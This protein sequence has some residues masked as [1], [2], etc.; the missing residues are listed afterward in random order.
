MKTS[1]SKCGETLTNPDAIFDSSTSNIVNTRKHNNKSTAASQTKNTFTNAFNALFG[2]SRSTT[3]RKSTPDKEPPNSP[4]QP[5]VMDLNVTGSPSASHASS[6]EVFSSSI[7]HISGTFT[8]SNSSQN[9]SQSLSQILESDG[10]RPT[11]TLSAPHAFRPRSSSMSAISTET[12]SLC[13]SPRDSLAGSI[14]L[15]EGY[16]NKKADTYQSGAIGL[17]RGWK[18]YR[19][20]LKGAKLYFYKPPTENEIRSIFP[21]SKNGRPLTISESVEVSPK[22]LPVFNRSSHVSKGLRLVS[23]SFA[24]STRALLFEPTSDISNDPF[25]N[26]IYNLGGSSLSSR[27]YF[28]ECFTE[29]DSTNFRFKRYVCLLIFE[30]VLMI[31]KRK[32]VKHHRNSLLDVVNDAIRLAGGSGAV[33]SD[34]FLQSEDKAFQQGKG[35]FTKW[36]HDTTYPLD[37]IDIIEA[38]STSFI[39]SSEKSQHTSNRTTIFPHYNSSVPSIDIDHAGS[40]TQAIQIF[41]GGHSSVKRLFVAKADEEQNW[42]YK[43]NSA[44]SSLSRKSSK[45]RKSEDHQNSCF[46]ISRTNLSNTSIH[47]DESKLRSQKSDPIIRGRLYWDT[48]IHPE[49]VTCLTVSPDG[50][51]KYTKITGGSVDSLIHELLFQN[52]QSENPNVSDCDWFTDAFLATYTR[53]TTSIHFAQELRR[54]AIMGVPEELEVAAD[55]QSLLVLNRLEEVLTKWITQPNDNIDRETLKAI[56][57]IAND[58]LVKN[59]NFVVEEFM[60][61]LQTSKTK[62]D[63][64]SQ[65]ESLNMSPLVTTSEGNHLNYLAK[66][67]TSLKRSGFSPTIFLKISAE[68]FAQE[69][70]VFHTRCKACLVSQTLSLKGSLLKTSNANT[71]ATSS[72]FS[73]IASV[74]WFTVSEPHFLTK[75]IYNHLITNAQS[76]HPSRRS[77]IL[78][79]WIRV[80]EACKILGDMVSWVAIAFA[81]CSPIVVRLR[82]TWKGIDKRMCYKVMHEWAPALFASG[83]YATEIP[84]VPNVEEI[85][86]ELAI[87]PGSAHQIPYFGGIRVIVDRIEMVVPPAIPGTSVI[88]FCKYQDIYSI[89]D[90]TLTTWGHFIQN[91]ESK[92]TLSGTFALQNYFDHLLL[93]EDAPLDFDFTQG[94]LASLDCEPVVNIRHL[95]NSNNGLT[96]SKPVAYQ[97]LKFIPLFSEQTS[98]LNMVVCVE[99]FDSNLANEKYS[100]SLTD[101]HTPGLNIP[102][103]HRMVTST[104]FF[105]GISSASELARKRTQS[106]PSNQY[107]KSLDSD[108]TS[109]WGII[110]KPNGP[111]SALYTHDASNL[112]NRQECFLLLDNGEL[113]FTLYQIQVDNQRNTFNLVIKGGL[114]YHLIDVLLF[115]IK[116]KELSLID[117]AGEAFIFDESEEVLFD[118]EEYLSY[119]FMTFRSFISP[120]DF[121]TQLHQ[122]YI[123]IESDP[124]ATAS[125]LHS[126]PTS[127][128]EATLSILKIIE[129]WMRNHHYD[130]VDSLELKDSVLA[131][132]NEIVENESCRRND[133]ECNQSLT[134]VE[135]YVSYI[136]NFMT[137][138]S[139]IP[140]SIL[141]QYKLV[142]SWTQQEIQ[143]RNRHFSENTNPSE[144]ILGLLTSQTTEDDSVSEDTEL[145]IPSID[146]SSAENL[147]YG[148]NECAL[149]LLN[150]ISLQ[151]WVYAINDLESQRLNPLAWYLKKKPNSAFEEETTFAD[152]F[153]SLDNCRHTVFTATSPASNF[154]LLSSLPSSISAFCHLRE[155]IKQWII[156]EITS[157]SIDSN[158]RASRI[159]KFVNMISMCH[160]E[161]SGYGIEKLEMFKDKFLFQPAKSQMIIPSFVER[162]I[163]SALVAPESRT[164]TKAWNDAARILGKPVDSIQTFLNHKLSKNTR[165]SIAAN[166]N[167]SSSKPAGLVPCIGWIIESILDVQYNVPDRLLSSKRMVNFEKGI[168]IYE[169]V[170]SFI[171]WPLTCPKTE[172]PNSINMMFLLSRHL[173][174]NNPELRFIKEFSTK[175]NSKP[176][177]S[178]NAHP[179]NV[180]QNRKVFPR[181][182]LSEQEKL[183]RDFREREKLEREARE[184]QHDIQ[185]RINEEARVKEKRMKE[186]Q[187]RRAKTKELE[188][189]TN[190]F[191]SVHSPHIG[192]SKTHT[193]DASP[194][195]L[196]LPSTPTTVRSKSTNSPSS[197]HVSSNLLSKFPVTRPS[198]AV[199]LINSSITIEHS[200]AKRDHVFK[201]VSEEGCQYLLQAIDR[202]DM[203]GWVKAITDAAKE[204]AAR[205]FTVLVEDARKEMAIQS[206]N[207]SSYSV[208]EKSSKDI[209]LTHKERSS[210]FGVELSALMKHEQGDYSLP[211][212]V[213]KCLWEV[214]ERG[215]CEVGIYRISG[216][217]SA[218][219]QLRQRFNKDC[220][221]VD[222]SGEEWGDINIVSGVLKQWLRELPEPVLTFDLYDDFITAAAIEDYDTRLIAIKN[223]V[224]A[225]PRPN[226]VLL[227]RLT[228]HLEMVTD[229]ED[230]NHMYASNLA[231]VFGPT[232]IRPPSGP[233]CFATSMANLGQQQA[234]VKNLILQYHWI[235][236]VEREVEQQSSPK[237]SPLGTLEEVECE[238][239]ENSTENDQQSTPTDL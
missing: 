81:V 221:A 93:D 13:N 207:R 35:Y 145:S 49:L 44:K 122:R 189:M 70:Y 103:R 128:S 1:K 208:I 42:L 101:A 154:N 74:F 24:S 185:R 171:R 140:I 105:K 47:K 160:D 22:K 188:K 43:F 132:F 167:G 150:Q 58:L 79:H 77:A 238:A 9:L 217:A 76:M 14:V 18:V 27:Y 89:V 34:S 225:L 146:D 112:S 86:S 36:K 84:I 57:A 21:L 104:S 121:L 62:L 168:L 152:I 192:T 100:T 200:R 41:V 59:E 144:S 94:F 183:K 227:K 237:Q 11:S 83:L 182:I 153:L 5:A 147:V 111:S 72:P 4:K 96:T 7:D 116:Q 172:N 180:V 78:A 98:F 15:K 40:N 232:L 82:E 56:E 109:W 214:E 6:P 115:G 129:Y 135:S 38:S 63:S 117:V 215:L 170:Q 231:I 53:F 60:S 164:F 212:L 195:T 142:G 193:V 139:L 102:T 91:S 16:L 92:D 202:Q 148:L 137:L 71:S 201:I 10:S 229:Y 162:A 66:D 184:R 118:Q 134:A 99:P 224:T 219:E 32:W 20:V 87:G 176:R 156:S 52:T 88:N 151:D 178:S 29:V 235:F 65:K 125:A 19:V 8:G 196:T 205:R 23:S 175:E 12:K 50:E 203:L 95:E 130:F 173:L 25:L 191:K 165:D 187:Q 73:G 31:C 228:E 218:I 161:M 216:M 204:G 64:T 2:R 199:N 198:L 239:I 149:E 141:N 114:I 120:S 90:H 234:I 68:D 138:S 61:L 169:L 69:L 107:S 51:S 136:I 124:V 174:P 123:E 186:R 223:L 45:V 179:N 26:P 233:L 108:K 119:F 206:S 39:R 85:L 48:Q 67:F 213:E 190:L 110:Q 75:L 236:D 220:E 17:G 194:T 126:P 113:I 127:K 209:S 166:C 177:N 54:C 33:T 197:N 155:A 80:A 97:P 106:M 37:S 46:S 55:G 226:Y 159:V 3:S 211:V 131:F 210:V 143:D 222:L 158:L 230:V 28:G 133:L 181:L 30:D 163:I 157:F